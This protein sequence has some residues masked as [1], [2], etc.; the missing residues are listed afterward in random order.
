MVSYPRPS[1]A[2]VNVE[3]EGEEH[4]R[5]R[6]P[7]AMIT[8]FTPVGVAEDACCPLRTRDVHR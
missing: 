1:I 4:W 3:A 7:P 5:G 8:V 6:A 2:R